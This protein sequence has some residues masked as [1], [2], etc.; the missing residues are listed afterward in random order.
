LPGVKAEWTAVAFIEN[1][2]RIA[3]K[4]KQGKIFSWPFYSDVRSLEQLAQKHLPLV[5]DE[6]GLDRRLEVRTSIFRR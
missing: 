6:N 1:N 2:T 5:R 4:T 3:A